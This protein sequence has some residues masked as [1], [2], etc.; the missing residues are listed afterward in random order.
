[1]LF[2]KQR[3]K[4]TEMYLKIFKTLA[5][6]P[7]ITIQKLQQRLAFKNNNIIQILLTSQA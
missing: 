3:G 6:I 7:V 2:V 1:M 5:R 4:L